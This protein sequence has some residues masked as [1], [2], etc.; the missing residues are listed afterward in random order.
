M[1]ENFAVTGGVAYVNNDGRILLNNHTKV[2]NNSALNTCFLF[3]I[4]TQFESMI[5]TIDVTQNDQVNPII[6]KLIFLK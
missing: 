2:Y 3:L 6:P 4:N 5:D 1:I